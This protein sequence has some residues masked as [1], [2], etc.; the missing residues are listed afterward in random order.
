M[1]EMKVERF[2]PASDPGE[3]AARVRELPPPL[4]DLPDEVSR[5]IASVRAGGDEAL[6]ELGERHDGIRVSAL[7]VSESDLDGAAD[8][9][10]SA[11]LDALRVAAANVEAVAKAQL[12]SESPRVEL[13]QGHRVMVRTVPVGSAGVY[14]PGGS[15]S[16]PS[17]VLMGCIPAR[18]AGV[19]RI[20]VATPPSAIDGVDRVVLAACA[21]AGVDEVYAVGGAQAIAMLAYG[22][23]TIAAVD[24]IAGPGSA[25][26]QEAKL[27]VSRDAG[28]DSYA[29]P[30]EL[31]VV[32]DDEDAVEWLALDVL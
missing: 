19:E 30:S 6:V 11:V 7:R 12:G 27:R 17:S 28:V 15:A 22:T 10:E 21:L 25:R 29:G 1:A 8:S 3:L 9:V 16:Y 4:G 23:E 31:M 18:V 24:V 20:A 5:T 14:V 26:V 32:F 2:G 13:P